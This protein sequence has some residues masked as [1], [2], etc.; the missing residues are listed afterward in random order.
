M[1]SKGKRDKP[2]SLRREK[3][4]TV[5][6]MLH[7]F[8]GLVSLTTK[9]SLFSRYPILTL[10]PCVHLILLHKGAGMQGPSPSST[11]LSY[12]K[13][14][15][16]AGILRIPCIFILLNWIIFTCSHLQS[17]SDVEKNIPKTFLQLNFFKSSIYTD[18]ERRS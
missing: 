15:K 2:L 18:T 3:V 14:A 16:E 6:R 12:R 10:V 17:L 1:L 9:F 4:R 11:S 13:S 7:F 5:R 8:Q